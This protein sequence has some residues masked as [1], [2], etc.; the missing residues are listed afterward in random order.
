MNIKQIKRRIRFFFSNLSTSF[1]LFFSRV[2]VKLTF[3]N[4]KERNLLSILPV[5]GYVIV[6]LSFRDFAYTLFPL[7][8]QNPEWELKTISTL[9]EQVWPFLIGLGFVFTRYFYE[10]QEDIRALE[11]VFLQFIRWLL[12]I[13]G[14]ISF[15]VIPLVFLDT[16]RLL[17]FFNAQINQQKDN[18]LGEITQAE[19]RL[20]KV[21]SPDELRLFAQSLK[22]NPD[23]LSLPAPELQNILKTNLTSTKTKIIQQV[24][25]KQR[26]Q[27]T[28][29][30]KGSIRT[31]TGLILN[32][33]TFVFVWF[34]I[35]RAF[36]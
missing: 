9:T 20:A 22:L 7:Q 36:K 4:G 16:N 14:I 34:R 10:K 18:A 1:S 29:L 21:A 19:N 26:E 24:A 2:D 17:I 3:R 31:I 12:L 8:L 5:F 30:W 11:I 15:L 23:V 33:V 25:Q 27:A 28:N 35:G 32:G 13:I 6:I